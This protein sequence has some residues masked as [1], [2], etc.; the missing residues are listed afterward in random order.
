[1]LHT[2]GLFWPWHSSGS[3][4]TSVIYAQI[5]DVAKQVNF[6]NVWQFISCSRLWTPINLKY[7]EIYSTP[8]NPQKCFKGKTR[9]SSSA[10]SVLQRVG[11]QQP[12]HWSDVNDHGGLASDTV[13]SQTIPRVWTNIHMDIHMIWCINIWHT[14]IYIFMI[15][16][17]RFMTYIYDIYIY[18]YDI[19]IYDIYVYIYDIYIYIWYLNK[20]DIYI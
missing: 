8:F 18:I 6:G 19:Y 13:V 2:P 15:Y 3:R 12:Y 14:Y 16:I 9:V 7:W 5:K 10:I 1:M 11:L 17:Y 4:G 20:Y